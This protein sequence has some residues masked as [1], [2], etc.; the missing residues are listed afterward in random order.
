M[1][2]LVYLNGS[3]TGHKDHGDVESF[4]PCGCNTY[5]PMT[6]TLSKENTLGYQ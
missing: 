4:N 5:C 6:N 1:Y 3:V 2:D